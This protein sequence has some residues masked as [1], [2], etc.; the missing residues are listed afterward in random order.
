MKC[1]YFFL[2]SFVCSIMLLTNYLKEV[3]M[4]MDAVQFVKK[5]EDI[6]TGTGVHVYVTPA[7]MDDETFTFR[8]KK[9]ICLCY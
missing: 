5:L 3:N 9:S 8:S 6:V 4:D 2:E 1:Q 7:N